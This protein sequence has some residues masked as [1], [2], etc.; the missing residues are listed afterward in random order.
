MTAFKVDALELLTLFRIFW[1]LV[2]L[3]LIGIGLV[4]GQESPTVLQQE[5]ST[6][7]YKKWLDEDVVYIITED[8]REIF[9]KL[10]TE[11]E[12]E[13]F[14]EQFWFRRNPDPT[15]SY[16]EFKEEHYRRI[17]YANEHFRSGFP[18]WMSD[19]GRIFIIHGPPAEIESHTSGGS[20]ERPM[21][22]GGGSTSTFP[23]EI[24]RYRVI[25]GIGSD[26][27]LEFVD[28]SLS[29]EYRLALMPEEKDALLHIPGAG[30]TIA[31]QM[32]VA[33]KADRPYFSPQ[34]R[35][36]YPMMIRTARD[37]P[38]ARYE[39]NTMV[40]RPLEIKYKDLKE[41]VE[42]NVNYTTLPFTTS[43]NYFHLNGQQVLVP[44]NM[45]VDNRDL[46]FTEEGGMRVARVAVYGIITSI[47][48]K[49]IAEFEDDL[50]TSISP[51]TFESGLLKK[52][53]YQKTV[54]LDRKIRY[55]LD[56]VIHDLN[57]DKVGV[58]RRAIVPPPLKVEELS[59]SSLVL[60][61]AIE[62]LED[63]PENE[64]FVLGDV[65]IRPSLN[66]QFYRDKPIGIYLQVY[67]AKID[68][69]SLRP[70]LSIHLDLIRDGKSVLHT[71]D[72]DGNFIQ[73]FSGQRVVLIHQMNTDGLEDG[74]YTLRVRVT[75]QLDEE[76]VQV[77]QKISLR[78]S[79]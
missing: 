51:Q 39:T 33:S 10:V 61:D 31:E 28:P 38:F 70:S 27:V 16:N 20:Y 3:S 36:Q 47:T 67:N 75:D 35:D 40:Q 4:F 58:V 66:N 6:D 22:E 68:Q 8:E 11:E 41:I 30:L 12:R 7:Y 13:Q 77:D 73:F 55:K 34:N 72:E 5:E 37:N 14:I 15:A 50:V 79:G 26:I 43:E 19:R 78:K 9:E 69:V 71:I 23:F 59:V 74:N 57:S 2:L 29:G 65:K 60:S 42:I 32:G 64:M 24:W 1:L 48:N 56:L 52:S 49:V 53:V 45:F 21:S 54:L 63:I 62:V 18:G 46:S 76:Q 25:D 44:I 17:A